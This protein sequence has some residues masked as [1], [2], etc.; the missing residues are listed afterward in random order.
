[1]GERSTMATSAIH[2]ELP[3]MNRN[4][5]RPTIHIIN[6]FAQATGGSEQRAIR[7][8]E[9]LKSHADVRLWATH[10]P[11]PALLRQAP[12]ATIEPRLLRFPMSG[13]FIFVGAYLHIGG[14]I[15]FARPTRRIIIFNTKDP[16]ELKRMAAQISPAKGIDDCEIVYS[17]EALRI[18]GKPGQVH[19]SPIDIAKFVNAAPKTKSRGPFSV[20]RLSRDYRW[21][22]HED[23]PRLFRRLSELGMRIRLL[24]G[25]CLRDEL[26]GAEGV[27]TLPEGSIPAAEFLYSLDCFIYR[28]SSTW[29]ESFGRVVFEA[30]ACELPVVCGATGG[31][32]RQIEHGVNGFI[33]DT[34]N[35]AVEI[36]NRLRADPE[37]RRAIGRRGRETAE[38]MYSAE[39]EQK[40]VEYYVFGRT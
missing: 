18:N 4:P 37:L 27:E 21:K 6:K 28:T 12:I 33:F 31:Y 8:A 36:L 39:Y 7:L 32:A 30:M 2:S 34:E 9:I 10:P 20:G 38:K 11:D 19:E 15:R 17:D 5:R 40:S 35:E 22:F 14:W 25:E 16:E 13:T 29:L 3:R 23:D 26:V 24:G 1:M